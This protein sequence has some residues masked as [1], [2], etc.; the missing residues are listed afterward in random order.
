MPKAAPWAI[1]ARR[2][3]RFFVTDTTR[4]SAD[5]TA[6]SGRAG[7]RLDV[8][9]LCLS[10]LYILAEFIF[11]ARLLDTASDITATADDLRDVE[12]LGRA[13]SGV[14]LSLLV[15][16]FF[17]RDGFRMSRL[18]DQ[19]VFGALVV[20]CP[21]LFLLS[22]LAPAGGGL[23]PA[24][25]GFTQLLSSSAPDVTLDFPPPDA[26]MIWVILPFIGIFA[27]LV[28]HYMQLH[29]AVVVLGVLMM[30]WP[31]MFFGQKIIIERFMVHPTTWE[32]RLDARYMQLM[33]T[34]FGHGIIALRDLRFDKDED[35]ALRTFLVL[36]GSLF[37]QFPD[38]AKE[39]IR[40]KQDDIVRLMVMRTDIQNIDARYADYQAEAE[41][42]KTDVYAPYA[43]ASSEYAEALSEPKLIEIR[44]EIMRVIRDEVDNGWLKMRD[45]IATCKAFSSRNAATLYTRL[46]DV[47][48]NFTACANENCR[49]RV[50]FQY[51]RTIRDA[52]DARVPY[53][54][55]CE[56]SGI[57]PEDIAS[58]N[59]MGASL[60]E[61]AKRET[62]ACHPAGIERLQARLMPFCMQYIQR[63][64]AFTATIRNRD[65]YEASEQLRKLVRQKVLREI[66]LKRRLIT[67][68]LPEDWDRSDVQTLDDALA[69]ALMSR[70]GVEWK[71]NRQHEDADGNIKTMPSNMKPGLSFDDFVRLP[72]VQQQLRGELGD[73]Y[74]PGFSMS[75][76]R[77]EFTENVIVPDIKRRAA[78]F[79]R[80]M[81][82]QGKKFANGESREAAGKE[83][84]RF[85]YIPSIALFIS[86]FLV[87]LTLARCLITAARLTWRHF[88]P[89]APPSPLRLA[90]AWGVVV[91]VVAGF[92]YVAGSRT[93]QS[94]SY[95][96]FLHASLERAPVTSALLDWTMR[97]EPV[98]YSAGKSLLAATGLAPAQTHRNRD[99]IAPVIVFDRGHDEL[100]KRVQDV[101]VREK[102]LD[103]VYSGGIM[104]D[105]THEALRRYQM[106]HGLKDSGVPDAETLK[107][108]G[109]DAPAQEKAAEETP[110]APPAPADDT[111]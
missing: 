23:D 36:M 74:Y 46:I 1:A 55:W 7:L 26:S 59:E 38:E 43:N 42:F 67:F 71:L 52:I 106:R 77:E 86:L 20:F 63:Q 100:V 39:M 96:A 82:Q 101:L 24:G 2:T 29:R 80:E 69:R 72:V 81:E 78:A 44:N 90:G 34:G 30:T 18:S 35:P 22:P 50:V 28:A 6:A 33:R 12:Y 89:D 107:L 92:P 88:Y 111:P 3:P 5:K 75:M 85:I 62:F 19:I 91:L 54:Y 64:T 99:D 83:A 47:R 84:V 95:Q 61:V 48:K 25:V 32:T 108:M 51:Q 104:N 109:I 68:M 9:L 76:T 49:G 110:P 66:R 14:G 45:S 27:V 56:T 98:I 11:N 73:M 41:R 15:A 102:T 8:T 13:V 103:A 58:Y 93:A 87:V 16:G 60:R 17:A 21:L 57:T 4:N 79:I 65:D 97:A 31:A 53:D 37:M 10:L 105:A 70:A 94:E 40:E